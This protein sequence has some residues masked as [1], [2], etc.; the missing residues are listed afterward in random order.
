MAH[1]VLPLMLVLVPQGQHS[2]AET[3]SGSWVVV[4]ML[5]SV[6]VVE[7]G[8]WCSNE[9]ELVCSKGTR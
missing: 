1:P 9:V 2:I 6:F 5:V 3:L 8:L 7:A 4:E